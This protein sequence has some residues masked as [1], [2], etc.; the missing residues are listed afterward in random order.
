MYKIGNE[1]LLYSTRGRKGSLFVKHI[2][3]LKNAFQC[4]LGADR[5]C[6]IP[7]VGKDF[8]GGSDG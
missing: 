1:N 2:L 4:T 8:P 3:K 5:Y 7:L 6:L